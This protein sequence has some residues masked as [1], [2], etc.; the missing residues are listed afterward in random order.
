MLSL[1]ADESLV[2]QAQVMKIRQ[3]SKRVWGVFSRW[4]NRADPFSGDS[5]KLLEDRGDF[6][7]LK[8]TS[9]QDRLSQTLESWVGNIVAVSDCAFAMG[10]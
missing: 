1:W 2:L 7:A 3:P 5:S 8:A 9:E 10:L 4:F 6:I